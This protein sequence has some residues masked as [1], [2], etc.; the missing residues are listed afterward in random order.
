MERCVVDNR[1]FLLG[2]D[3]LYREAMKHHERT[4]LL[5]C[6]RATAAALRIG[7]A[8]VPV[9]GYYAEEAPLTEY[10]RLMCALQATEH[11]RIP[12]VAN[13]P[14]FLRLKEVTESSIFG[15][16]E[17]EGGL[18]PRSRDSLSQ[19]LVDTRPEW[20]IPVLTAAAAAAARSS[21]DS[22]L[23]GLAARA[24]DSVVLCALRESIVIYVYRVALGRVHPPPPRF[25]WAVDPD[26]A[27]PAQRFIHA[28]NTLFEE[29]LPAAIPDN[30]KRYW[31][32]YSSNDIMGRCVCLGDD[33]ARSTSYY[34]WAI[35]ND[36]AGRLAVQEFWHPD[37]WTTA[38]Y[39]EA[40]T[41]T[42]RCP[43]L[44][45]R[46]GRNDPDAYGDIRL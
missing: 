34:H 43:E 24:Q 30:T 20:T 45:R 15:V 27:E 1:V 31:D 40:M 35:C 28:F 38:A 41:I 12:E 33:P 14:S 25:V 23:V 16:P 42:G 2:L 18:L 7:P 6:A 3:A 5:A 26:L 4:E 8:D 44:L 46:A 11:G 32:A 19:A 13:L 17:V 21:D 9:E 22:S 36:S 37:V 10:F 29:E 39:R